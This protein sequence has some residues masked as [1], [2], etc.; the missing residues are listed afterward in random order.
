[1]LF[2]RSLLFNA[3]Y[4][5]NLIAFMVLGCVF[6]VTPRVWSI[7][8]LKVWARTSVWLLRVITGTRME[9]RGEENIPE[10]AV[11][12]AGKHQSM[13]ETFALLPLLD[14]PAVVL[15]RELTWIPIFGWFALK[16]QMLP[17][18][19]DAGAGALRRLIA[20]AQQIV[21]AKRQI[22]IFPEGTRRAPDAPPD[23]KPGAAALRPTSHSNISK[24]PKWWH[25][26]TDK[27]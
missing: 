19:R 13:W 24:Q 22:L 9:V 3:V 11:L 2:A 18:D 12:V 15:K 21:A 23:Y 6:Y 1:M 17:V 16:F 7:A 4:Y 25:L 27:T 8:A 20:R 10:G 26:T 14:D 5:L